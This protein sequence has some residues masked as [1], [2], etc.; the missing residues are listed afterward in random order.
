[1]SN[2]RAGNSSSEALLVRVLEALNGLIVSRDDPT[3]AANREALGLL[4]ACEVV[5]E[6]MTLASSSSG[7]GI[8]YI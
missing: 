5:L 6:M 1:L 7:S 4:G 3:H 8:V 2:M